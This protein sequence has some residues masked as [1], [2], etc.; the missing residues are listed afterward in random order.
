VDQIEYVSPW[1]AV[2]SAGAVPKLL[3]TRT[4]NVQMNHLHRADQYP[5]GATTD[6]SDPEDFDALV[7]PGGVAN[8][9]QLRDTKA[10]ELVAALFEAGRPGAVICRGPWTPVEAG[11][12]DGRTLTSWR[13]PQTTSTMSAEIGST[14]RWSSVHSA[15]T[16]S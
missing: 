5:V 6:E 3:A 7:R 13:S 16:P 2:R 1:D 8:S 12:V 4:G 11:L 15:Q 10:I 14:R 9:D